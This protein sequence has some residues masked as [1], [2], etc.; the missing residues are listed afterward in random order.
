M[1]TDAKWL[2]EKLNSVKNE[3]T[4]EYTIEMCNDL[5][6]HTFK[7]PG[8]ASWRLLLSD[9]WKVSELSQDNKDRLILIAE[10]IYGFA[11]R[12]HKDPRNRNG[13]WRS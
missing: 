5:I 1:M 4:P 7:W 10:D 12:W 13:D 6:W 8:V 11:M 3:S 2:A 9:I